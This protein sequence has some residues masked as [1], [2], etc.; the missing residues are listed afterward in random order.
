M[1]RT[2]LSD[3]INYLIDRYCESAAPILP[4]QLNLHRSWYSSGLN[5]FPTLP[6][7]DCF[8]TFELDNE[9]LLVVGPQFFWP[10][11]IK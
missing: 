8:F 6:N 4:S 1:F 9:I 2:T 5:H 11:F 7:T 10:I 3:K